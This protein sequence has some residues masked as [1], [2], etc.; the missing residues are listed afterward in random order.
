MYG[1]AP[2][3]VPQQSAAEPV[4]SCRRVHGEIQVRPVQVI[5]IRQLTAN[6]ARSGDAT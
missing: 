4:P 3:R 1:C 2:R 5:Q 6:L